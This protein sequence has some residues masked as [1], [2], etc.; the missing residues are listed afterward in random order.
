MRGGRYNIERGDTL[1]KTC[2][3]C[4]DSFSRTEGVDDNVN[5]CKGCYKKY[6]EIKE[7][8]SLAAGTWTC[9]NDEFR[10][11]VREFAEEEFGYMTYREGSEVYF[12]E[13]E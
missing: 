5:R 8:H 10:Q 3:K 11:A 2:S 4:G 9:R 7:N 12:Y 1:R 13:P 6:Q